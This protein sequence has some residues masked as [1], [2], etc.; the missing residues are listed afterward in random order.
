VEEA[1]GGG[2][3]EEEEEGIEIAFDVE[4]RD[5][6]VMKAELCPGEGFKEFVEGAETAG[7]SEEGVREFAHEGFAVVHGFYDV[8]VGEARVSDFLLD[9]A[10]G[11]DADDFAAGSKGGVGQS[12][13]EADGGAAVDEAEAAAGD[14]GAGEAG[15]VEAGFGGAGTG[16]AED[17]DGTHSFSSVAQE[18]RGEDGL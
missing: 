17:A 18:G 5:G 3:I 16:A 13:H 1:R 4:E 11:D 8:E 6:L 9:K 14:F 2:A 15:G 7:K 10:A 12:A